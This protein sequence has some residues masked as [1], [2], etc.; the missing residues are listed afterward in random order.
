[1]LMLELRIVE[2]WIE[3]G[4]VRVAKL[5]PNIAPTLFDQLNQKLEDIDD[6]DVMLAEILTELKKDNPRKSLVE[7]MAK[8]RMRLIS[9]KDN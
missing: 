5:L 9:A 8:A 3:F 7:R 2:D 6:D 1:M 4:N